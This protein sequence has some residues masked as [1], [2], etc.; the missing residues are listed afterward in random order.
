MVFS[1][2]DETLRY[3]FKNSDGIE[4]QLSEAAHTTEE[5]IT[6][7]D[8]GVLMSLNSGEFNSTLDTPLISDEPAVRS[9]VDRTL[10]EITRRI[11]ESGAVEQ[12]M[13]RRIPR[14]SYDSAYANIRKGVCQQFE[15]EFSCLGDVTRSTGSTLAAASSTISDWINELNAW[16]GLGDDFEPRKE[17][18]HQVTDPLS[19]DELMEFGSESRREGQSK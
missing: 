2:G 6:Q 19:F 13:A 5:D 4:M 8:D 11:R 17:E 9:A 14:Y 1:H 15:H 7:L 3:T 12:M 10:L 16:V 18:K